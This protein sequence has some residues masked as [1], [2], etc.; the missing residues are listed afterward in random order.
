MMS[1]V[2]YME[3]KLSQEELLI[4]L[5]DIDEEINYYESSYDGGNEEVALVLKM[6]NKS[7]IYS[8]FMVKLFLLENSKNL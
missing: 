7:R 3:K 5:N 4:A 2:E 6:V 1:L 8:A